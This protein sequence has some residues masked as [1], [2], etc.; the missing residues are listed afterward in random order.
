[1]RKED[2]P[3]P[4]PGLRPVDPREWLRI[5]N[6][7]LAD[8]PVKN[9]GYVLAA[10]AD[11]KTGADIHPGIPLLMKMSGI[12]SDKTVREA[13]KR[14]REMGF[15]WRYLEGSTAPFI[16]TRKGRVRPSDEYRLTWPDDISSIPMLSPDDLG[17]DLPLWATLWITVE[18]R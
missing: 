5:W 12:K 15:A 1:V 11:Y 3:E 14:I 10:R 7:V 2:V 13:L 6:R 8:A 17:G 16:V 9:V 4:P 18:H